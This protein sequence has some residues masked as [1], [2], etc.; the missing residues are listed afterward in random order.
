MAP[1]NY[2]TTYPEKLD[3]FGPLATPDLSTSYAVAD[4]VISF[5]EHVHRQQQSD[6]YVA[7]Y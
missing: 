1:T 3:H 2:Y 6:V 4:N 7:T 5:K